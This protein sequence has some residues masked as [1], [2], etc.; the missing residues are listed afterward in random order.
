MGCQQTFEKKK[1]VD[2]TQQCFALLLQVN[3]PTNN[4]NFHWRWWDWMLAIFLNLFYFTCI[5]SIFK[6]L[7]KFRA[8]RSL[9]WGL[10][11]KRAWSYPGCRRHYGLY[12]WNIFRSCI[13]KMGSRTLWKNWRKLQKW[14]ERN[15][16]KFWWPEP[17]LVW[18]H[19]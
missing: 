6:F 17:R 13:D 14:L 11:W 19:F 8:R 18:P 7:Y 10:V 9:F 12:V 4:L 15:Q 5:K 2:I 16:S 3:F 1:F